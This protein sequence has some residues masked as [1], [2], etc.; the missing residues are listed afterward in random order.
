MSTKLGIFLAFLALALLFFLCIR[1]HLPE[2]MAMQGSNAGNANVNANGNK[3]ANVKLAASSLKVA[4]ENGKYR[5]TGTLPDEA[6][7]QQILTKAREVYGEGNFIDEL[8]IGGVSAPSWL[9]SVISLFPFTKN[10]VTGGG[11]SAQENS[12]SLIGE[13]PDQAAKDKT[14][15]DAVKAVPSTV[16]INNLLTI[17]GKAA[18]NEEQTSVQVKLNEAIAGK[19]IEF[20][21]GS[22]KL[23]DKGKAV[24]DELAPIFKGSTDNLEI[25]GNT[26]NKGNPKSNLDLSK[27]RAEAVKQY[28]IEKGLSGDRFTAKGFGQDKPIADNN[29]EDGRQRNRRIDFQVV[30]GK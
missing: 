29:T 9:S 11:L 27:R 3:N 15:A 26:D 22:D 25:G 17:A 28:L 2:I 24:L 18:L 23:T 21:T 10:G 7:K 6:S 19:I 8:K 20:E 5:L 16:T 4:F 1:M 13:V 14:Y 12:I 30:G